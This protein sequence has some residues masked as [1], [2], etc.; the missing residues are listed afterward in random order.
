MTLLIYIIKTIF[1]SAAL[2][3]Y[4]WFF[5]R[6]RF[7]HGFNRFFLLG[8]PAFSLIIPALQLRIPASGT[9]RVPDRPPTTCLVWAGNI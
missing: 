5:L 7:F 3:G 4:Y 2:F 1:I 6:N 8:I 9:R